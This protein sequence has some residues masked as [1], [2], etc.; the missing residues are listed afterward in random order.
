MW[1][2]LQAGHNVLVAHISVSSG[3]WLQ[4]PEHEKGVPRSSSYLF[5]VGAE[6]SGGDRSFVTFKITFQNRILLGRKVVR[7]ESRCRI[8][9]LEIRGQ[10]RLFPPGD[11]RG[12]RKASAGCEGGAGIT[13]RLRG[14]GTA[15]APIR[16]GPHRGEPPASLRAPRCEPPRDPPTAPSGWGSP[17]PPAPF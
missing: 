12:P 1:R 14:S 7:L 6:V 2:E 3:V 8:R 9:A 4:T 5:A 16:R 17:Q 10:R 15:P 13:T 11:R